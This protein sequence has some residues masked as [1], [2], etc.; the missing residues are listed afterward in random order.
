MGPRE[1]L[2]AL[3]K[4]KFVGPGGNRKSGEQY[5]CVVSVTFD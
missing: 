4:R 2:D 5:T 1:G 3:V